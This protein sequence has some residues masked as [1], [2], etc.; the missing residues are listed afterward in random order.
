MAGGLGGWDVPDR[1]DFEGVRKFRFNLD[2]SGGQISYGGLE[3]SIPLSGDHGD[4]TRIEFFDGGHEIHRAGTFA[5]LA[6]H[7]NWP[8]R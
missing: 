1:P 3:T 7:L 5:F 2:Y 4:R 8:A 6:E